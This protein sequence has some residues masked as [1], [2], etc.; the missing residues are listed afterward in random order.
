[1]SEHVYPSNVSCVVQ[2]GVDSPTRSLH[3]RNKSTETW[4]SWTNLRSPTIKWGRLWKRNLK[5]PLL[6]CSLFSTLMLECVSCT[7]WES[8]REMSSRF[9]KEP[10]RGKGVKSTKLVPITN[11]RVFKLSYRMSFDP[12]ITATYRNSVNG[13]L[14]ARSDILL[15]QVAGITTRG[16]MFSYYE[17]QI[18]L[19]LAKKITAP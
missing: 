16:R 13:S 6:H 8:D 17:A 18:R 7:V 15:L 1:M 3:K 5:S 9:S 14:T 11:G 10:W 4:L 12:C 19:G 2:Q